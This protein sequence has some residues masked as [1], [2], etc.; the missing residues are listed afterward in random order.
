[1]I[2]VM[3]SLDLVY[4]NTKRDQ[5]IDPFF[6][7]LCSL[8]GLCMNSSEPLE[9]ALFHRGF[10][11]A[12]LGEV[13]TALSLCR[14]GARLLHHTIG[15]PLF[16]RVFGWCEGHDCRLWSSFVLAKLALRDVFPDRRLAYLVD[17]DVLFRG[18]IAETY[19]IGDSTFAKCCPE[20]FNAHDYK[21]GKRTWKTDIPYPNVGFM[22]C[23][24]ERFRPFDE[25]SAMY[26]EYQRGHTSEIETFSNEQDFLAR[27]CIDNNERMELFDTRTVTVV[28]YLLP[29][30][31]ID[32]AF[33]KPSFM[34]ME[35][36]GHVHE[37]FGGKFDPPSPESV[38]ILHLTAEK[39]FLQFDSGNT[40]F[41]DFCR[42]SRD[43]ASRIIDGTSLQ[44]PFVEK[45]WTRRT[46][47]VYES[48]PHR[49]LSGTATYRNVVVSNKGHDRW[50]DFLL[51]S[52]L[53]MSVHTKDPI[54]LIVME[55]EDNSSDFEKDS[56]VS[57]LKYGNRENV[58]DF[59]V[60]NPDTEIV[61]D[62]RWTPVHLHK[63]FAADLLSDVDDYCLFMDSDVLV[64]DDLSPLFAVCDL[65]PTADK[66]VGTLNW[67]HF[68][69]RSEIPV[70]M[71]GGFFF[72][73]PRGRAVRAA[74]QMEFV[75]YWNANDEYI[76]G[77]CVSPKEFVNLGNACIEATTE[78][79]AHGKERM[80]RLAE[81]GIGEGRVFAVH[82]LNST[83]GNRFNRNRMR[84]DYRKY[85][86]DWFFFRDMSRR[87]AF[88]G[89]R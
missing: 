2:S 67:Y 40:W 20:G 65:Q 9:I 45:K 47:V 33:C 62:S 34:D 17:T 16:D 54:R 26:D 25:F 39:H 87:I 10:T 7:F 81:H 78:G 35:S 73:H 56:L 75:D 37:N 29:F 12:Q 63:L 53:S 85:V 79:Y 44:C 76:I 42:Q 57:V 66:V 83:N 74:R 51:P 88:G 32:G 52:V 6:V 30:H 23:N 18:D 21:C 80:Q 82:L 3:Y 15:D 28:D 8:C 58:A 70:Q 60:V 46:E 13:D 59:R 69:Q 19:S 48:S 36:A 11:N 89:P 24:L 61:G 86:D 72:M 27:Y 1:M 64:V 5:D 14:P 4:R 49:P 71:S 84:K 41:S 77:Q 22:L 31:P 50:N 38:K 55:G 68:V 43:M